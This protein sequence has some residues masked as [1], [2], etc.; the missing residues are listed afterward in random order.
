M[1][2]VPELPHPQ[3]V[4]VLPLKECPS[5]M[6]QSNYAN[7][8]FY[9]GTNLNNHEAVLAGTGKK[10]RH[11]KIRSIDEARDPAILRILRDAMQERAQALGIPR[12]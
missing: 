10:L 5:L 9:H 6:P 2:L 12:G 7:L 3:P 4:V 1:P 11:V 8:G